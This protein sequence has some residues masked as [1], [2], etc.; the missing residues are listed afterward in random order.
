M[1]KNLNMPLL[2]INLIFLRDTNVNTSDK[3]KSF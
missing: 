3:F 2:D 1:I